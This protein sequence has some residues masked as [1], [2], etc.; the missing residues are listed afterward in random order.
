MARR[1]CALVVGGAGAMIL[2]A[3]NVY[4]AGAPERLSS[5]RLRYLEWVELLPE[6]ERAH[7]VPGAPP[8][9]HG[10]LDGFGSKPFGNFGQQDKLDCSGL[11]RRFNADCQGAGQASMSSAV[12]A[13]LDGQ[14]VRLEGYIVPLEVS[15]NGR[16]TE[17]F[18]AA[19]AGAC[20]HV[21]PPP[22][23]QMVYAKVPAKQGIGGSMYDAYA[24]TGTLKTHAKS[25]GLNG[26]AYTMD[27]QSIE[28][29]R[30]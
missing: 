21:P 27:V 5:G 19:Y 1:I 22:P 16:V 24:L 18:L 23:N 3:L 28:R 26:S 9:A 10:Y 2:L 20:I 7:Y 12:N 29:I 6:A 25:V 13:E 17:F 14:V 8:P 11:A 15:G 4:G 30:P